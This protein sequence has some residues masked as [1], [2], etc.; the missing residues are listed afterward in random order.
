MDTPKPLRPTTDSSAIEA[1]VDD[2]V[3]AWLLAAEDHPEGRAPR[4]LADILRDPAGLSFVVAFV[5]TV[6]RP[7]DPG[8]AA[9]NLLRLSRSV[10]QSLPLHQR[11]ALRAGGQAGRGMP[12]LVIPVVRLALRRM[13]GHLVVDARDTR[14]TRVT[15]QLRQDGVRLNVNLLGEAVLGHEEAARRLEGTRRLLARDDVDHVSIKVSSVSGPHSPWAHDEVVAEVVTALTPLFE[16]AAVGPLKRITLDMEEYRDLELTFDVFTTLLELPALKHLTAGIVLQAYLPD[17]LEVLARLQEWAARRRLDGGAPIKVRL[18]KGANLPMERV[19]AAL[20][21]WPLAV[22]G[23]KQETDTHYK[24]LL[25]HALRPEH[26][27]N[28]RIGVAGHNL[29][30]VAY[31]WLLAGRRGVREAIEFEM[32][33]GMAPGQAEAV[34]RTVGGLLLYTPVVHPREFDVAISYLV[35]RLEE[36]AGAEN[37]MSS[38]FELASD[39]QAYDREFARFKASLAG[40]DTESS[41]PRRTQDRAHDPAPEPMVRFRNVAD[42][43]PS[44]AGNRRWAAAVLSRAER[45]RVGEETTVRASIDSRASL[46]RVIVDATAGAVGWAGRTAAQ[47]AAVLR[48]AGVELEC[49]RAELLEV[50]AHECGKTLDQSD[51]EVSEAID[52]AN[53]YAL[54]AEELERVDGAVPVPVEVTVVTPP[55]NFP[56]AIPAGSTLA[57]LATGSAVVLK[58]AGAARRCGAVLAEALWAAGVPRDVLQLVNVSESDLGSTLVGDPRVGRVVLTGAYETAEL[59]AGFRDDLVLLAETSGKNAIVVT[60]HADLD[61]AVRDVVRSAFGHAGQK[62]SAASLVI[63]VGSVATSR[64]FLQQLVD[65]VTSL[66]VGPA[67]DVQTEMGPLIGPAGGKLLRALTTLEP[68]ERWMVEP[69]R[70]DDEGRLWSPGVKEGVTGGSVTHLVEFFGP[71]LGVMTAETLDEAIGLQNQV[72]YGLTAG[73]HSLDPDEIRRWIESVEAGNLYVNRATTGAV[74]RRQPFGGWKKSGVGPGFK[75][76]GRNHLFGLVDWE[77]RP[78]EQSAPLSRTSRTILALGESLGL[79][80]ADLEFLRRSLG[81][82]AQA[83]SGEFTVPTDESGLGVERNVFRYLPAPTVVRAAAGTHPA[84][85][86]RVV[87]AGVTAGAVARVSVAP[88]TSP[89]LVAGVADLAEVTV[90]SDEE[91]RVSLDRDGARRVRLLGADRSLLAQGGTPRPDL[92]VHDHAVVESGRVELLPFVLEQSI[93]LTAHRFGTPVEVAGWLRCR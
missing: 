6:I 12:R 51:P 75:A 3:R 68:G 16:S 77:S 70:L 27:E 79:A 59:F 42:T 92:V 18:V 84:H 35:R 54:S 89:A 23:S 10:P 66:R 49:R 65:A 81:S 78:A 56:V 74:V 7:Q 88:E 91:W 43:D 53:F 45:S 36:G 40:L 21:D 69:R 48:Q 62:C 38:V 14:F 9:T 39:Q 15:R 4:R 58:P 31:A 93:S 76:G 25:D 52:F 5:D 11:V 57:A 22:W 34:R 71:V 86:L 64:R 60:P 41:G 72:E 33:L 67:W 63:L 17:S 46:E 82:D 1:E 37:F 80:G 83:W 26:V 61:L 30:D 2:L 55:W 20:H 87:S 73:L 50:M 47:R 44:L 29:F 85:L 90:E 32:L 13:V 24:R 8:V 28:V 19:D